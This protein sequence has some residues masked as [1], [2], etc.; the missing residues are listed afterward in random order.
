[1]HSCLLAEGRILIDRGADWLKR[2]EAIKPEAIVLTHSHPDHAD[3][4]RGGSVSKVY[5]TP[6]TWQRLKRW[7]IRERISVFPRQLFSIS[8]CK[9]EA[10]PVE[11]SLIAPA[12]G[13]R[14]TVGQ[15]SVFYVP[16]VAA[17]PD[18]REA[19]SGITLYVG[20][21]ASITRPLLRRRNHATIG[22]CSIRE[23]LEWCREEGITN[24][25]IT[26]CD[27]QIVRA[28]PAFASAKIEAIGQERG[29]HVMVA[30]D[31][32]EITVTG[33]RI[34]CLRSASVQSP[35]L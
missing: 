19:P 12:V 28:D 21:G 25:I 34:S 24:A 32:L 14:I 35:A 30:Q 13:Y 3:G 1:M 22:H 17:I 27:S 18:R 11:H 31:G 15:T 20:D 16:D 33:L 5:A 2:V 29:V 10:F 8:S 9:L 23:Q 26:H 4:L 6:E 7:P